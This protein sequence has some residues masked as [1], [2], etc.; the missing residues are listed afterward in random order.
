MGSVTRSRIV[1]VKVMNECVRGR[2]SRPLHCDLSAL[3][4][5][6]VKVTSYHFALVK[7]VT[8]LC[9]IIKDL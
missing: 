2:P 5:L 8:L 4:C 1:F 3:L 9:L 6:F 7:H